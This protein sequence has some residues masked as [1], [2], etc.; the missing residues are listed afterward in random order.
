M[1]ARRK[2]KARQQD[3]DNDRDEMDYLEMEIGDSA[4][5]PPDALQEVEE[6][7]EHGAAKWGARSWETGVISHHRQLS[8]ILRHLVS[9]YIG[10]QIKDEDSGLHHLAHIAA[11]CLMVVALDR[12]GVR[13][14]CKGG[15]GRD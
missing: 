6:V 13:R 2:P 3:M 14:R 15:K 8:A 10:G 5:L 7:F 4:L 11:R 12:R 1:T 9:Y